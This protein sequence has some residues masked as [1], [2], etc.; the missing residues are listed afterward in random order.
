[1]IFSGRANRQAWRVAKA[2]AYGVIALS[3]L[4]GPAAACLGALTRVFPTCDIGAP[5]DDERVAL[6]YAYS[7]DALSSVSIGT[8]ENVTEVVDIEIGAADKPHYIALSSGKRIIWR[9]S[10]RTDT[11]S[12]VIVLGSQL[13]GAYRAGVIGVPQERVRF[14]GP[15]INALR[16]API[17]VPI[18]H[19]FYFACDLSTYFDIPNAG[20]A[21]LAGDPPDHRHAADQFVEYIKVGT[22]RIPEDSN[23]EADSGNRLVRHSDGRQ[24]V[25][26]P[27]RGG[28]D[29]SKT[30]SS[31]G[32][33]VLVINPA[34]VVSPET[35]KPYDVLPSWA[36]INQL[37]AEGTLIGPSSPQFKAAYEKWDDAISAPFRGHLDLDFRFSYK[38]DYLV[39]RPTRLPA[40]I[41]GKTFLVDTGVEAP[42]TNGVGLT[43]CLFFADQRDLRL[44]AT[45]ERDPRCD[46]PGSSGLS[47]Q[48][49]VLASMR[50]TLERIKQYD[51]TQR[52][53][54]RI[55]SVPDGAYFVGISAAEQPGW[56]RDDGLLRRVDVVVR[57]PGRVALYLEMWGGPTNWHIVPAPGTEIVAVYLGSISLAEKRDEVFGLKL[58]VPIRHLPSND[59]NSV[60]VNF[61]PSRY[62]NLGG[63]AALALDE[64][65]KVLAGRSL[66]RLLREINSGNWPPIGGPSNSTFVID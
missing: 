66:D 47:H 15:D 7:G 22:I 27:T 10:G 43:T 42:V 41:D 34:D 20:R 14:V 33:G 50:S 36:G 49:Q 57:H 30:N 4:S 21:Q 60:C 59:G 38:V 54:C 5:R 32:R 13:S 29:Y 23:I 3:A 9:F 31:H 65:L 53:R 16:K 63:P 17:A 35:V 1:M 45:K 51:Q 39:T 26:G 28:S 61:N 44:D 24:L 37:L 6:V 18:C 11:I 8:D 62:A 52:E 48:Q 12:R 2:F 56:R 19:W 40:G 58:Q 25:T 55:T 46:R 64:S